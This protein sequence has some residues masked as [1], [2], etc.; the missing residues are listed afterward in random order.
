MDE[1]EEVIM[2]FV[3]KNCVITP[4]ERTQLMSLHRKYVGWAFMEGIKRKKIVGKNS[5]GLC[6]CSLFPGVKKVKG[7]GGKYRDT[8]NLSQNRIYLEGI[9]EFSDGMTERANQ[10]LKVL[11][12]QLRNLR[13]RMGEAEA[14]LWRL[15]RLVE[16]GRR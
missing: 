16:K 12:T 8:K 13:V 9:C 11:E 15:G 6:V 5:F 10:R 4:E 7:P 14:S 2:R 1:R 3:S